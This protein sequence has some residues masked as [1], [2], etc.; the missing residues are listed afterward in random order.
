M[1]KTVTVE[2]ETETVEEYA[3]RIRSVPGIFGTTTADA[4]LPGYVREE[5]DA[6]EETKRS[7]EAKEETPEAE[8]VKE[9]PK[10]EKKEEP[11]KAPAKPHAKRAPKK[12]A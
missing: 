12:T 11:K 4:Y 2:V 3:A 1:P 6:L 10:V 9:E 5:L 8:P 7:E